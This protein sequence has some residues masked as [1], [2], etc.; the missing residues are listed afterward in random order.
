MIVQALY[1]FTF[2]HAAAHILIA[3][4]SHAG[5]HTRPVYYFLCF[6]LNRDSV[7]EGM[8]TEVV[9][10]SISYYYGLCLDFVNRVISVSIVSGY[11]LHD[12]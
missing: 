8:T 5:L 11:G 2:L 9:S 7:I 10:N 12:V 3:V 1:Q 6:F 4:R